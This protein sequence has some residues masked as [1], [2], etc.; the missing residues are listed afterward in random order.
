MDKSEAKKVFQ[1]ADTLYQQGQ[2]D[3]ALHLLQRLNREF[4][5]QKHIM[6]SAA[7]C[8]EQLGRA[9]ESIA[10]CEQLIERFQDDRA[11]VILSRFAGEEAPEPPVITPSGSRRLTTDDRRLIAMLMQDPETMTPLPARRGSDRILLYSIG[12]IALAL[13]I[14]M[15]AGAFVFYA[16]GAG[17][18]TGITLSTNG[19]TLTLGQ[20]F[21]IFLA[22]SFAANTV[23]MFVLLALMGH[24]RYES[25]VDNVFDVMQ[26]AFYVSLLLCVPVLGWIAIPLILRR[27]YFFPMGELFLF[28]LLQTVMATGFAIIFGAIMLL[29]GYGWVFS[30]LANAAA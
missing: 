23:A 28:L 3:A 6:Y 16:P 18:S 9:Q 29:L 30:H 2:Y 13:T 5:R 27:H 7:L 24:Q 4:P 21:V 11:E 1:E 22:T 14:V 12:V 19:D 15:A 17:P 26:Y 8:L 25:P 20:V 10:L